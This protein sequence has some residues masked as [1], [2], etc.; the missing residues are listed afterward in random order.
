MK[1]SF[2]VLTSVALLFGVPAL[3]QRSF[4]AQPAAGKTLSAGRPFLVQII[5]PV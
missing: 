5:R 1:F 2:Q 3:A 4:I